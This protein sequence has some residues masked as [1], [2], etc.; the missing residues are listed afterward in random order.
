MDVVYESTKF[1]EGWENEL[2]VPHFRYVRFHCAVVDDPE[3]VLMLKKNETVDTISFVPYDLNEDY[4]QVYIR[5]GDYVSPKTR[6]FK[7]GITIE[8]KFQS[9]A[10]GPILPI[11][12]D[13]HKLA[14]KLNIVLLLN[15]ILSLVDDGKLEE[16]LTR[17]RTLPLTPDVV[18]QTR[19]C[20]NSLDRRSEVLEVHVDSKFSIR[21]WR[22]RYANTEADFELSA[23]NFYLGNPEAFYIQDA[24]IT[25]RSLSPQVKQPYLQNLCS[26]YQEQLLIVPETVSPVYLELSHPHNYHTMNISILKITEDV[27]SWI[28]VP[29]ARVVGLVRT[30][31]YLIKNG[32]YIS[33]HGDGRIRTITYLCWFDE[34]LRLLKQLQVQL[35]VSYPKHRYTAIEDL[36]DMRIYLTKDKQLGFIATGI[37]THETRSHQMVMGVLDENANIIEL[38][39]LHYADSRPQKNWLPFLHNGKELMVYKYEPL[40]IL[41]HKDDGLCEV[42]LETYSPLYLGSLRGSSAPVKCHEFL[43]NTKLEDAYWLM[44]V[45]SSVPTKDGKT[46]YLNKFLL[47]SADF[48]V[49]S[50]SR[51]FK[52]TTENVEYSMGCLIL[53][54]KLVISYSQDDR[55]G[56]MCFLSKEQLLS[57]FP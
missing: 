44:T 56:C 29:G 23:A 57:R 20:L 53:G 21:G 45:H 55:L 48:R 40:T 47:M 18:W 26:F 50:I 39:M 35:R 38:T 5:R 27:A 11:Y 13:T 17:L 3:Y 42:E 1:P 33:M 32:C 9:E 34:N 7:F 54:D 24:L 46:A 52:L 6:V 30:V 43:A 41:I 15:P 36:E 19:K 49:L 28:K 16:A 2:R 4:Y 51:Y 8:D 12:I 37:D 22:N 31:N 14:D 25:N 10:R